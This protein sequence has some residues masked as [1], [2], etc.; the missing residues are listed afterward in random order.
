MR[1]SKGT[2]NLLKIERGRSAFYA[3]SRARCI[4]AKAAPARA[5]EQ[6][7]TSRLLLD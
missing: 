6:E 2:S 3:Q 5:G 1:I 4:A 7:T